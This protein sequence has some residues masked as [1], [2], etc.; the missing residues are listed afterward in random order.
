MIGEN[1]VVDKG[2]AIRFTL[3][4]L[5]AWRVTHL[6]AKEDG[7]ADV[8]AQFRARLGTGSAGRLMDC[9]HCLSLWVAA[10][11][12]VFTCRKPLDRL[13]AWLA[14]SGAACLLE[15]AAQEPV[16]FQPN[17][18]TIQGDLFDGMLR[19]ET[20]GAHRRPPRAVT[21]PSPNQPATGNQPRSIAGHEGTGRREQ[22]PSSLGNLSVQLRYI[23]RSPILVRGP[24]TGREYKFSA[25]QPVEA[26]DARDAAA[27]LRTGFF[28]QN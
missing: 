5:A 8:L 21:T 19:S 14:L 22:Y 6:L 26:I 11:I 23:E 7:P 12:A 15:R 3:A 13:L 1:S 28:R 2:F 20:S 16:V 17:P 9:F 25:S 24:V 4:V 18:E 10:P 27:L